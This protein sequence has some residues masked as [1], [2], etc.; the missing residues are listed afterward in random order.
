M[1]DMQ[2]AATAISSTAAVGGLVALPDCPPLLGTLSDRVGR[3]RFLSV[4]YLT[5][6]LGIL[7]LG[8]GNQF[9]WQFWV[10]A[11]LIS[12]AT[13]SNG[14][15]A[16]ALATDLL[17]PPS[18]NKGMALFNTMPWISGMVGYATTGYVM[19]QFGAMDHFCHRRGHA[20]IGSNDAG[21]DPYTAGDGGLASTQG[22]SAGRIGLAQI[23][24]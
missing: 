16:S 23:E 15:L 11:A 3:K 13:Y 21:V 1:A 9:Y 12:I 2:F 19:E 20:C 17:S 5:A 4:I 22:Q 8:S 10:A 14:S 7:T 18:M 24:G 6:S